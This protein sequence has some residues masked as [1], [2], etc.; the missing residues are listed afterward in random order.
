MVTKKTNAKKKTVR[1][2]KK[3]SEEITGSNLFEVPQVTDAIETNVIEN[4][5]YIQ[6]HISNLYDCFSSCLII[7]SSYIKERTYDDIQSKYLNNLVVAKGYIGIFDNTQCLLEIS[8]KNNEVKLGCDSFLFNKPIPIS[9]IKN[10]IVYDENIKERIIKT[11]LSQD[12]GFIPEH[13]FSFYNKEACIEAIPEYI[14]DEKI[15]YENEIDAFDRLLGMFAFTKNQQLYYTNSMNIISNYSEHFMEALSLINEDVEIYYK[16]LLKKEF[17][18]SYEKLFDYKI[19]DESQPNAYII[20]HLYSDGLF[21]SEFINNFFNKYEDVANDK[22]LFLRDLKL[23]LLNQI[24]KKITLQPLLEI[25]DKFF[26]VAYLYIYGKKG[27]NDKDILK[28]LIGKELPYSQSEM[29]LALL[30]MYYGYRQL[31][32]YEKI[33][34]DDNYLNKIFGNEFNIKFKLDNKLD[35]IIIE[36]LYE[37]LFNKVKANGNILSY[38]P[39]IKKETNTVKKIIS[40]LDYEILF[41]SEIFETYY[42]KLRKTREYEKIISLMSCYQDIIQNHFHIVSFIKKHYDKEHYL[43]RG[44]N[45]IVFKNEFIRL[46]K[47]NKIKINDYNHLIESIELDKKYNI[48]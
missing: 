34:F 8:L 42:Y 30:G 27:S 37:L 23:K 32:L 24:G 15:N 12:V 9:R 17:I 39:I 22:K 25:S 13:L 4:K 28:N 19:N 41:E 16:Q 2:S 10:I 44:P 38:K 31:R 35:Y 18:K 26:K 14:F 11:A 1:K 36:S 3:T 7:P 20:K 46:I 40:K 5:Y 43:S 29:T 33:E 6:L 45:N 21:D 48:Q 47:E